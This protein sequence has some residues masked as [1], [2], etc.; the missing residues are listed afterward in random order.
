MGEKLKAVR[1]AAGLTQVKLAEMLEVTQ[2]DISHWESGKR[3]PNVLM[4]KKMAQV[5]GCTMEDLV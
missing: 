5:L 1:E 4:V 3:M 2:R